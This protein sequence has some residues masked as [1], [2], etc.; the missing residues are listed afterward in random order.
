MRG[1]DRG[2]TLIILTILNGSHRNINCLTKYKNNNKCLH[3]S[4]IAFFP[5][6]TDTETDSSRKASLIN[7]CPPSQCWPICLH[8]YIQNSHNI[9]MYLRKVSLN[10]LNVY[11]C[12]LSILLVYLG[13]LCDFIQE[14][15]LP[16]WLGTWLVKN[17]KWG[18]M[19]E[20]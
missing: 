15:S 10:C 5:P 8:I 7:H 1:R 13:S 18:N 9:S 16:H 6:N 11:M 17:S 4:L 2:Q 3:D 19:S 14:K 20:L 12:V